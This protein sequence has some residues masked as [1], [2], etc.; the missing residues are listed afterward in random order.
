LL[1]L[2]IGP[3]AYPTGPLLWGVGCLLGHLLAS[4][5]VRRRQ[6][7][8]AG[9]AAG[10]AFWRAVLVGFVA[11]RLGFVLPAWADYASAPWQ[12]LDL[13][14]GGWAP[15]W[16]VLV[17]SATLALQA[18]RQR[19][20]ALPLA[21]GGLAAL[22]IWA[23]GSTALGLHR[24]LPLPDIA[25]V[26]LA[27][28]PARLPA[29]AQGRP[30][31]IN[32]WATWCGPCRAEMPTLAAAWAARPDVQF[33]FV[34]QG[35][36]RAVVLRYPHTKN[37]SLDDA[38]WLDA[39]SAAGPA[40]DSDGLPTTLFFDAQGRLVHRQVGLVSASSLKVRL[41]AL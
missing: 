35:E 22:S 23:G 14:D 13:R 18:G 19:A 39:R 30:T 36:D 3:L 29:L 17:A 12:L 11:A 5:W 31:V 9:R 25:L 7:A 32:L 2:Q 40:V 27:G 15:S 41:G 37:L 8:E 24:Q 21:A 16:G 33:L 34:N 10:D 6:G 38:V 28:Q 26:S 4:R 20:M 1:A